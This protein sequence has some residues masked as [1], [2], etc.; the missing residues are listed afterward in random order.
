MRKSQNE[1]LLDA[2]A[3]Q[4]MTAGD[5]WRELGIARASARVYD[6]RNDGF[7]IQSRDIDVPTRDGG[8]AR[9]ALYTLKSRQRTLMAPHPGRGFTTAGSPQAVAA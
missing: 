5:I 1:K 7:D 3:R 2:L 6:L 4:P 8:T 9:V